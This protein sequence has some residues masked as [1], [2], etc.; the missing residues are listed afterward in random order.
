MRSVARQAGP[1]AC[2]RSF[3]VLAGSLVL[4]DVL[5]VRLCLIRNERNTHY[6]GRNTLS[7]A[8]C[9]HLPQYIPFRLL[10]SILRPPLVRIRARKP[11]LRA[12][13]I[14]LMRRFSM[15]TLQS[16]N[17]Q[18]LAIITFDWQTSM[19]YCESYDRSHEISSL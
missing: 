16:S 15:K 14:L 8:R 3:V 4:A 5:R 12:L 13:L 18:P 17:V 6:P 19:A 2:V 9:Y 10:A 7:A 1:S 11:I